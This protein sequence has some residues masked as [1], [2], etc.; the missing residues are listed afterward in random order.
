YYTQQ[1]DHFG[2]QT[3]VNGSTTFEQYYIIQDKYYKPGGPIF[4][5][6]AG[7]GPADDGY[8][9]GGGSLLS[10]LMPRYNG[11][12]V[13]LEHRFYGATS[14]TVGRSVPTADLSPESLKLLTSRQAIEDMASFIRD[15]PTLFPNYNISNDT[16]WVTVGGS[17]SGALSAWMR[18][19]HP[20]LVHAAYAASAPVDV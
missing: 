13:S 8:M 15:F 5:W 18:Q 9:T 14:G 16:K 17:Y 12:V 11:L 10:W 4:L 19:Q 1:V 6:I 2:D 7:E 3:G 20:E